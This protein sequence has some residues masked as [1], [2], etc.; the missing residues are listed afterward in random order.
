MHCRGRRPLPRPSRQSHVAEE[1]NIGSVDAV[2]TLRTGRAHFY[3]LNRLTISCEDLRYCDSH[4]K[5]VF[6]FLIV[7]DFCFI[8][9]VLV[10][11]TLASCVGEDERYCDSSSIKKLFLYAMIVMD[12]TVSSIW[13]GVPTSA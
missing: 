11:T 13:L 1:R 5:I 12:F 6:L 9:L 2:L 3:E 8:W 10:V 7:I 4:V